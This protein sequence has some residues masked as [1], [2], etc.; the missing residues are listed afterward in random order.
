[1]N[2]TPSPEWSNYLSTKLQLSSRKKNSK[3]NQKEY[4]HDIILNDFA[5][6]LEERLNSKKVSTTAIW[7]IYQDDFEKAK[8]NS[9]PKRP[10]TRE[11]K[12]AI[13]YFSNK[14]HIHRT[15][16]WRHAMYN[17]VKESLI[18]GDIN[19]SQEK[20]ISTHWQ[21]AITESLDKKLQR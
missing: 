19:D 16:H 14:R 20:T 17:K 6:A 12:D 8:N 13:F 5:K 18:P 3:R 9:D 21:S 1:M 10:R 15:K 11:T 7:K 2:N 4:T